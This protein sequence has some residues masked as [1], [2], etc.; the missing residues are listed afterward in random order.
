MEDCAGSSIINCLSEYEI[1]FMEKVGM[2]SI[3]EMNP[4]KV[5]K[6][7]TT[8]QEVTDSCY[9]YRIDY[10]LS[11]PSSGIPIYSLFEELFH[12]FQHITYGGFSIEWKMN[13]EVEA[14]YATFLYMDR[15]GLFYDFPGTDAEKQCFRDYQ[16]NPNGDNYARIIDYVRNFA[17]AY[18]NMSDDPSHRSMP[19]IAVFNCYENE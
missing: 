13:V 3:A 17:P 4:I 7:D 12:C 6:R 8:T 9:R 5:K 15:Y 2:V 1:I 16:L 11:S 14:K 10:N 19:N 18:E